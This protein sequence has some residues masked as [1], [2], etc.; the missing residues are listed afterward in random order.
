MDKAS[1]ATS[2]AAAK[3]ERQTDIHFDFELEDIIAGNTPA[4][5]VGKQILAI[6]AN[7]QEL[8]TQGKIEAALMPLYE[9][10]TADFYRREGGMG[11]LPPANRRS[12]KEHAVKVI[13]ARKVKRVAMA[14]AARGPRKQRSFPIT[15]FQLGT[16]AILIG[17]I[18]LV[19]Y[20]RS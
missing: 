10:M 9:R 3:A 13:Q 18:L 14:R 2:D 6:V 7:G 4:S 20:L 19:F 17:V 11:E 15:G 1:Q 8:P 12:L 5:D 16:I